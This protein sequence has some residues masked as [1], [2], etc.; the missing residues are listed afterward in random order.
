MDQSIDYDGKN[1]D[2]MFM[3][4]FIQYLINAGWPVKAKLV[5]NGWLEVDTVGDLKCY[6]QMAK[7]GSLTSYCRL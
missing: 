5:K 4:S 7:N 6:D 3:T 2:N 1:F